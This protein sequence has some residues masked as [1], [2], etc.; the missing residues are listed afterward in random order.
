[1]ALQKPIGIWVTILA[2]SAAM[3]SAASDWKLN[4]PTRRRSVT[5]SIWTTKFFDDGDLIN[6]DVD[7]DLIEND[8]DGKIGVKSAMINALA[9]FGDEEGV[10]FYGG[11]GA[12]YA[13]A[14]ALDDSDSAFAWQAILGLRFAVSSNIDLGLKYRYFQTGNLEFQGDGLAFRGP[15]R[16]VG[17]PVGGQI[18]LVDVPTTPWSSRRS[19]TSSV[20]TA[21]WRA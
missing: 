14:K 16:T 10:S 7:F 12:G 11:L 20:R 17:I 1:M 5:V 2:S 8:L 4:L 15:V 13:W 9:D 6:S 21:C 3:I 19:T 18:N